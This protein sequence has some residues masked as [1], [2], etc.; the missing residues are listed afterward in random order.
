[1]FKHR[2]KGWCLRTLSPIP[3]G[4]FIMEYV[5]ERIDSEVEKAR[6]FRVPDMEVYLMETFKETNVKI[7]ALGVRNIAAFAAFACRT[8]FA[9]MRKV[10]WLSHHWD[11]SVSHAVYIAKRDIQPGE[12]LTYL[13][14]DKEPPANS[15][16]NCGCGDPD[17][18]G[19]L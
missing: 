3:S 16:K 13:R 10:G 1:M 15:S 5:G 18:S 12:E 17:C 9:N 4:A 14:L 7:D 2:Y 6:T 11:K 8:K 19:K